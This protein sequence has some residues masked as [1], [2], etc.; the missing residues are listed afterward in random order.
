MS[1]VTTD[2]ETSVQNLK[3]IKSS[4]K[5]L[6]DVQA[7]L[8]SIRDLRK[9]LEVVKQTHRENLEK[10]SSGKK[11]LMDAFLISIPSQLCRIRV[12]GEKNFPV[13]LSGEDVSP[14]INE[15]FNYDCFI[16]EI[17]VQPF[18]KYR[19]VEFGSWFNPYKEPT[20]DVDIYLFGFE[21]KI[22]LI[23][24]NGY[25]NYFVYFDMGPKNFEITEKDG[26]ASWNIEKFS[27]MDGPIRYQSISSKGITAEWF[28]EMLG[29][30]ELQELL[31]VL[32]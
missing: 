19:E 23:D 2:L 8:K 31:N 1:L 15:P 18:C 11:S 6:K 10:V 13:I 9:K 32:S 20:K 21:I 28:K 29:F 17:T 27:H 26:S 14:D 24:E 3:N 25:S 5:I 12:Y 16:R 30:D 22:H 7:S 4:K